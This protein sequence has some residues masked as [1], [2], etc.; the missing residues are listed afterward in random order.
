M[1]SRWPCPC[2]GH[3]TLPDGPGAYELCP[4]CFWEDDGTQLRWPMSPDGANG[5]SLVE[6][7]QRYRRTGAMDGGFRR[8]VRR[9]LAGELLDPGWRPFD[10]DVDWTHPEMPGERWPANPEALYYWRPT[11]WNGDPHRTPA[12]PRELTGDDRLVQHL[13]TEVPEIQSVVDAVEWKYGEAAPM[14]ICARAADVAIGAYRDGRADLGLRI[15]RA[16][17]PGLDES[18]ELYAPNCVSI[19]FLENDGWHDDAL[20]HFFDQWPDELRAEI[21]EQLAHVAWSRAQSTARLNLWESSRGQPIHVVED[22]LRNL[23]GIHNGGL[24][25]ELHRALIARVLSDHRWGFKHPLAALALAWRYRSVQS[26]LRT[27]N[28]LRRPRFAG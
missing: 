4:V 8:K 5:I 14:A 11:Y 25:A 13:I 2:C 23:D 21:R 7:Q 27:L 1:T 17:N 10:A 6:A 15:A 12:P 19:S 20:L 28:W 16:L 22:Q 3:L 24:H 9:P 26:P 18:S